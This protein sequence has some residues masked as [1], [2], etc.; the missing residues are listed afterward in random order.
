MRDLRALPKVE[1][2]VHLEGSMRVATMVELADRNGL[3]VPDG[4]TDAGWRFRDSL[5]FIEQYVAMCSVLTRLD[6]F[7]RIAYE[8]CADL[9]AAGVRYAEAAFSPSNHAS[10]MGD[11]FGPIEAVLDGLAAGERDFGVPVVLCPDIIRD[12]GIEEAERVLEVALTF[13]GRGVVALNAS[14]SEQAAVAPFGTFFRRAKGGG[15]RSVPH[16]GE[17]AGP[18]NVWE[19]LAYEPDRIGHGVRSIE[20]P[21]LVELLAERSIP[22]EIAPISNI[23]TGAYPSLDQHP[24]PRLRHAGVVVTLN[25]DD[26]PM[27]G[28]WLDDVYEAA[29]RVWGDSDDDLADL[30]RAGVRASFADAAVKHD[31]LA[32]IDTWLAAPPTGEPSRTRG[33]GLRG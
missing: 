24:L 22:L 2:H 30:A 15:L 33:G 3:A 31:V 21:R 8:F 14:G 25:S 12:L 27:F 4:L 18:E 11:R 28:A 1:L 10:R 26:P 32:G 5:D 16:A 23:A 7:R 20:D 9:A 6:D 29:R 17:W 19:T 13:A